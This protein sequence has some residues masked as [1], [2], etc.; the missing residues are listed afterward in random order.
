[1][2]LG[3]TYQLTVLLIGLIRI[4][5]IK[6]VLIIAPVS[7]IENWNRELCTHLIPNTQVLFL[8]IFLLCANKI[9]SS[10]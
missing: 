10:F 8:T 2:G 6:K 4:N 7:V 3:K 9:I 1:M 5:Q